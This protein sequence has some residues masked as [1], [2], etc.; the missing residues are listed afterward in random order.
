[1]EGLKVHLITYNVGTLAPD[2]NS[3]L[4]PLLPQSTPDLVFVGFQEVNSAPSSV[5]LDTFLEGE[6]PWTR[7]TK[8]TLAKRGFIK[9]KAI[10]LMG[11]VLS[12]FC[13][14]KH[15]PYIRGIET[16]YTRLGLNGYWGNKG[17]VSVRFNIYGVSVCV[18]NSHLAAHDHF[19]QARID[20]YNMV[21]G[22]HTYKDQATELIMYNDYVLWMGDLNFRLEE[23]TFN[24]QEIELA[25]AQNKLSQLLEV[26]QLSA[27]RKTGAAFSELSETLPTFPPTFKYKVG[28]N[29]FDMKRR[30]A[31]T[32]RILHKANKGNYDK[33]DLQLENHEYTSHPDIKESDHLP[34]TANFTMSVFSRKLCTEMAIQ[35][36]HPIVNFISDDIYCGED[37]II[38]YTVA[39]TDTKFLKFWDWVGVYQVETASIQD[40]VGFLWA[41]RSPARDNAYEL[42]FDQTVFVRPGGYRLVYYSAE[43]RDILG[44]SSRI[45]ARVRDL[46]P[47]LGVE[48]TEEL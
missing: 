41:P 13:L 28:T 31:W 27:V 5:L 11:V 22:S 26:D 43:T 35:G 33:V 37:N 40:H 9:I 14:E 16:Q 10:R 38:V 18:L 32:D 21:L 23:D 4:A 48:A 8:K 25:V 39:V 1:M 6:D 44:L 24:F 7:K 19:N 34:V 3:S 46:E 30:P 29:V 42:Y 15:V 20:S 2:P 12:F 47:E 36:V 45:Q 17:T